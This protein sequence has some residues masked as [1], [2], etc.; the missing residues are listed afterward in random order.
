MK[1][2]FRLTK[3]L[4]DQQPHTNVTW[5]PRV[6]T[7]AVLQRAPLSVMLIGPSGDEP[8]NLVSLAQHKCTE[9]LSWFVW[10]PRQFFSYPD[11]HAV[12]QVAMLACHLLRSQSL[13]QEPEGKGDTE[14]S[15]VRGWAGMGTH[16]AASS[17][18]AHPHTLG[19]QTQA[20][21]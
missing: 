18:I 9:Q 8:M 7:E 16:T 11:S 1:S 4:T 21:F 19:L 3:P 12:L 17:V 2:K 6:T 13:S 20:G 5:G 14:S 10:S 15:S